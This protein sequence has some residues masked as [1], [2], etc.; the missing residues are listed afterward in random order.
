M[1]C[2]RV[3]LGSNSIP[4]SLCC[5]CSLY[6]QLPMLVTVAVLH[7]QPWLS[8]LGA[9]LRPSYS[10]PPLRAAEGE[11]EGFVFLPHAGT[12]EPGSIHSQAPF[13]W[14]GRESS[15]IQFTRD[16]NRYTVSVF[17]HNPARRTLS[18]AIISN[19]RKFQV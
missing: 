3:F 5:P 11:G 9:A 18:E 15:T 8:C 7:I 4:R 17:T 16:S 13:Q 19:I 6:L 2:P 10:S 1:P 12:Y 14:R